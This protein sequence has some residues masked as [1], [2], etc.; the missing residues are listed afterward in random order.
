MDLEADLEEAGLR[1]LAIAS[2]VSQ[3]L[4]ALEKARPD[5][6]ILDVNLGNETSLPLAAELRRR[7]VP[8]IFA[9]GYGDGEALPPAHA[10]VPVVRKPYDR[11]AI[12]DALVRVAT[13]NAAPG[14]S[15]SSA[16]RERQSPAA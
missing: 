8:F 13:G 10:G 6:A 15:H 3:G 2:S 11:R 14:A 7:R 12:A 9:T 16:S 4:D 5:L 1:V